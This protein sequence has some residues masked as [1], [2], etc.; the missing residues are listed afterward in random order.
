RRIGYHRNTVS[1]SAAQDQVEVRLEKDILQLETQVVTGQA[2]SVSSRNVAN[3][4]TVV[5]SAEVNRVPQPTVENGLQG[6]IPG[7]VIT[8]KRGQ[9]G[10]PSLNLVQRFGTQT[11]GKKYDMRCFSLAEAQAEALADFNIALKPEDYAGCVD[12]QDQL[13]GNHYLSYE[14][15]ASI[16]GGS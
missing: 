5:T 8:T 13:F 14:T 10:T 11:I 3:A 16:R 12:P 2:T 6:K 9:T 15:G 7:A 4:V 1:L